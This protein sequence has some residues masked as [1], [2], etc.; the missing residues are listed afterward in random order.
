M[1]MQKKRKAQIYVKVTLILLL[2]FLASG[3]FYGGLL[4][5]SD[6]SGQSLQV[7]PGLLDKLPLSNYLLP[8]LFLN[9]FFGI[10]PLLAVFGLIFDRKLLFIKMLN[11]VRQW[12]WPVTLSFFIGCT[13][14]CWTIG[15]LILW[16]V[17]W[18]SGI[19]FVLSLII[20][21]FALLAVRET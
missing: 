1:H 4:L 16:D 3:G 15:E 12:K 14:F 11:P 20:I 13:L 17:N 2:L 19:Y 7:P 21:L 5:V 10:L 8:A 6:P 9:I 18:L